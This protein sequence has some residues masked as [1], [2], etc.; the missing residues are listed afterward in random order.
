[1]YFAIMFLSFSSFLWSF[2]L[3]VVLV[4]LISVLR[5]QC[6]FKPGLVKPLAFV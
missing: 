6:V 1:M 3:G 2:I 4:A 5:K